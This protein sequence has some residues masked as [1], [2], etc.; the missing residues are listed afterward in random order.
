MDP[1]D[2]LLYGALKTAVM[3]AGS[4]DFC[5]EFMQAFRAGRIE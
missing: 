3:I 4:D 2:K 1:S 5:V